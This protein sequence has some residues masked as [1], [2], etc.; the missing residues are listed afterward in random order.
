MTVGDVVVVYVLCCNWLCACERDCLT[1][2]SSCCAEFSC[3]WLA[4]S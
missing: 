2:D 1:V 4:A 3:A